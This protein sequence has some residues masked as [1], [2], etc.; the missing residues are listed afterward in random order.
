MI[1][2]DLL[3][4]LQSKTSITSL[5]GMKIFIAQAPIN[6]KM[7]YL[8]IDVVSGPRERIT[9]TYME[10]TAFCRITVNAGPQ[11]LVLG[12]SAAEAAL[13]AMENYRG[14]MGASVDLSI[15]CGTVRDML[16]LGGVIRYSFDA[17]AKTME[18]LQ[19]PT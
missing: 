4:Y 18:T 6:V 1:E 2:K 8:I 3:E 19:K 5:I 14:G 11:D 16:G 13:R 7:P 17:V 12:R 15:T 9:P 10:Q